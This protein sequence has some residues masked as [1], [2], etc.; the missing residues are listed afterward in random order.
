MSDGDGP[1]LFNVGVIALA[2]TEA[3][4]RDAAL[5]YVRDAITGNIDAVVP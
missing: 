3:L 5:S 4:V 1:Y 2:H